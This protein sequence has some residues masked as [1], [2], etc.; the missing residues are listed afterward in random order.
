MHA[1]SKQHNT[2]L[3]E[4]SLA[5]DLAKYGK[6]VKHY[7]NTYANNNANV[8]ETKNKHW[9]VRYNP[10]SLAL[11]GSMFVYQNAVSPQLGTRCLYELSCSNFSKQSLK[12]FGMLKGIFLT[13][14]RLLRC[15]KISMLDLHPMTFNEKSGRFVDEP[16]SYRVKRFGIDATK[17]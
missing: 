16:I 17:H 11:K 5:S 8:L 10:I 3:L 13:A 2:N 9:L 1:Q 14:D 12:E 6:K 7:N 15:N 4:Q